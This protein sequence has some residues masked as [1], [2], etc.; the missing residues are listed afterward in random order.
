[1]A[2]MTDFLETALLN[3]VLRATAYTAP[4][5]VYAALYT[6]APGE[7]GGGT[8]V[9][10]GSY[11]RKAITFAAPVAG[12]VKNSGAIN[13]TNMPGATIVAIAL[14]DAATAGNILFYKSIANISV[15]AGDTFTIDD[16][17]VSVELQ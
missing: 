2:E 1:M 9:T 17:D 8:E 11:A 6:A 10:G 7:T 14:T 12:V 3:H 13:F 4:A 5:T 16:G 15:N